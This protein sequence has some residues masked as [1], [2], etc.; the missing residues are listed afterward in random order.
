MFEHTAQSSLPQCKA[1]NLGKLFHSQEQMLKK[2]GDSLE[3]T[4]A[5]WEKRQM[6]FLLPWGEDE[7]VFSLYKPQSLTDSPKEMPG[8]EE[9]ETQY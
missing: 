2:E 3:K 8:S 6:S 4:T 7:I 5:S 9:T 1:A